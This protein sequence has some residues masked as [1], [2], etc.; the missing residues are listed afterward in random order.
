MVVGSA[1]MMIDQLSVKIDAEP[2]IENGR[3]MVP[4]RAAAEAFG[5]KVTAVPTQSGAVTDILFEK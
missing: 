2:F 5:F 1:N 4:V 3:T